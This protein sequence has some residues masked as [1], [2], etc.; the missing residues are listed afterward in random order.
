[1]TLCYSQIS[2]NSLD[3]AD[4]NF[5]RERPDVAAL[6]DKVDLTKP[7]GFNSDSSSS[8]S[9]SS[10]SSDESSDSEERKYRTKR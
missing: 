8:G 1:M 9:S 2:A 6:A 4:I 3:I 10:S 7:T 5:Q